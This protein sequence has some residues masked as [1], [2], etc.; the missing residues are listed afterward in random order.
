MVAIKRVSTLTATDGR[1][2]FITGTRFSSS[3]GTASAQ[4]LI[5]FE[6]DGN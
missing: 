4:I 3:M 1:M 2:W 6:E 5:S